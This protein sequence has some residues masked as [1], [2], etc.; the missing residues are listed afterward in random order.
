MSILKTIHAHL[1]LTTNRNKSHTR[2]R[3]TP[4]LMIWMTL[5]CYEFEFCRNFTDLKPTMAKR[6]KIQPYC[7]HGIVAH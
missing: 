1:L 4:R 5:T 7:R 2:F 3:L 6:M